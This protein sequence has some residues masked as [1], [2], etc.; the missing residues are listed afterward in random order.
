V[1]RQ[2]LS[3]FITDRLHSVVAEIRML[4]ADSHDIGR[5]CQF[6]LIIS[7]GATLILDRY[8]DRPQIW[9]IILFN[10]GISLAVSTIVTTILGSL[11]SMATNNGVLGFLRGIINVPGFLFWYGSYIC[12][13][14]GGC[15]GVISGAATSICSIVILLIS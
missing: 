3:Q 5:L 11:L 8:L 2:P 6:P 1:E 12:V 4:F 9:E 14:I 13:V 15:V 10:F 7:I